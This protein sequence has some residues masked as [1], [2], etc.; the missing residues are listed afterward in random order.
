MKAGLAGFE[1]VTGSHLH[2]LVAKDF[3]TKGWYQG[4]D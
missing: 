4:K 3:R 1:N 2:F